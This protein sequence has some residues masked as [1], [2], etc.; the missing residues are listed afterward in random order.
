M[1]QHKAWIDRPAIKPPTREEFGLSAKIEIPRDQL[2]T[3]QAIYSKRVDEWNCDFEPF[4]EPQK[5]YLQNKVSKI[6]AEMD[7]LSDNKWMLA[8][9]NMGASENFLLLLQKEKAY[10]NICKDYDNYLTWQKNRNPTRAALEAK[11]GYDAKFAMHLIR[12]LVQ[13]KE[14]LE[15]GKL[16][17]RRKEDREM[18][19]EIR[20]CHWKYED[21]IAYAEKIETEVEGA[22]FRSPFPIQPNIKELDDLCIQLVEKSL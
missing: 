13:G 14:V 20:S 21:V 11:I 5:I 6:L 18:F 9:R 2:L 12:L 4:S 16:N 22:Y 17:V 7:I 1:K 10:Q 3:V 15:T 19:L 8:A